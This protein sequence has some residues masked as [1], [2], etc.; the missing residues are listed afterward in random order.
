MCSS[1]LAENGPFRLLGKQRVGCGGRL[2]DNRRATG[3]GQLRTLALPRLIGCYRPSP[4]KNSMA[5][6]FDPAAKVDGELEHPAR[7]LASS[8][9]GGRDHAV[10]PWAAGREAS[11]SS[12]GPEHGSEVGLFACAERSPQ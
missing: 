1:D 10:A 7:Q 6:A 11:P 9:A 2:C 12:A 5:E 3:V 8:A 4:L